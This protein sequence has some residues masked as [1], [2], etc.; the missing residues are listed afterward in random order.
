M[1][2]PTICVRYALMAWPHAMP[3]VSARVPYVCDLQGR[4]THPTTH[5]QQQ[6]QHRVQ[7]HKCTS[8][9]PPPACPR[10]CPAA[11]LSPQAE[12]PAASGSGKAVGAAGGGGDAKALASQRQAEARQAALA[13]QAVGT[14]K[15]SNFFLPKPAAPKQSAKAEPQ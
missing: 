4:P 12:P 6:P 14:K 13:K 1:P 5:P 11:R 10:C 3:A 8:N 9:T 15:I 7:L 2:V